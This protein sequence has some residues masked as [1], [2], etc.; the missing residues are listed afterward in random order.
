MH[1]P[2]ACIIGFKADGNVI[3]RRSSRVDDVTSDRV[4]VVVNGASGA[5]NNGERM[6]VKMNRMLSEV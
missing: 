6:A 2:R 3:V 1:N 4:V 5:A